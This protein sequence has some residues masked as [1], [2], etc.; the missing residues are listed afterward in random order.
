MAV[1]SSFFK[2]IAFSLLLAGTFQIAGCGWFSEPTA[3]EHFKK[4]QQYLHTNKM[5]AALI[6][7]NGAIQK[8]PDNIDYRT[9]LADL[10]IAVDEPS[11]AEQEL[12]KVLAMP[13]GNQADTSLRLG[14][15]LLNANQPDK[16]LKEIQIPKNASGLYKSK[17]L[18]LRAAAHSLKKDSDAACAQFGES[19]SLDENNVRALLGLAQC[20]FD[21]GDLE[22]AGEL[23]AV[24]LK[25]EPGSVD[26]WYMRGKLSWYENKIDDAN[27]A[28]SQAIKLNPY[29]LAIHADR[30]LIKI[31]KND[32]VGAQ[33]DLDAIFGR[34]KKYP[35]A[36]VLQGVL[37]FQNKKYRE[38]KASVEAALADTP[39]DPVGL[40]CLGLINIQLGSYEQA[41]VQINRYMAIVPNSVEGKSLLILIESQIGKGEGNGLLAADLAKA[42]VQK[43]GVEQLITGALVSSGNFRLASDRME[44]QVAK[45]QGSQ[46]DLAMLKIRAKDFNGAKALLQSLY[47]KD[48]KNWLARVLEIEVLILEKK[49]NDVVSRSEQL[50]TPDGAPIG[51]YYKAV[52]LSAL[53]KPDQAK[54]ALTDLL[55]YN[56]KFYPAVDLLAK[57][58]S[59][60]TRWEDAVSTYGNYLKLSPQDWRASIAIYNVFLAK[61]D[62]LGA[63]KFLNGALAK[64]PNEP[65]LTALLVDLMMKKKDMAGV[66][67]LTQPFVDRAKEFPDLMESR[68]GALTMGG[69]LIE[70][71]KLYK[72]MT[73]LNSRSVETQLNAATVFVLSGENDAAKKLL[74]NAQSK[75]PDNSQ[76]LRG[77]AQLAWQEG[78][79]KQALLLANKIKAI[80]PKRA[81]GWLVEFEAERR[82]GRSESALAAVRHA[83]SLEPDNSYIHMMYGSYLLDLN[84]PGQA[85]DVL[86]AQ[87]SKKNP[88]DQGVYSL[89]A[90][91]YL[92]LGNYTEAISLLKKEI[93]L[94]VNA[95]ASYLQLANVYSERKDYASGISVIN[96]LLTHQPGFYEAKL[97]LAKLYRDAKQY[98]ESL[99]IAKTLSADPKLAPLGF[100]LEGD[101]R[102]A[103]KDWVG[104][105]RAYENANQ[106][107]PTLQ[108]VVGMYRVF[109]DMGKWQEGVVRLRAWV[110][111]N[112]RDVAGRLAL[113]AALRGHGDHVGAFS[114]VN[115]GVR[116]VPESAV[117]LN[118]AAMLA[119]DLKQPGALG[120]AERAYKL[121]PQIAEVKDTYGWL[122]FTSGRKKEAM[123]LLQSAAAT[124]V[125]NPEIQYH[126]ALAL[127]DSGD[128]KRALNVM[129]QML[130][131]SP[132]FKQRNE[133]ERLVASLR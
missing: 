15:A 54:V 56:P 74:L 36:M 108:N 72:G 93:A 3:E 59:K 129:T 30:A 37:H 35:R 130:Q 78:D 17:V 31:L 19:H 117:L 22:K 33:K 68:A 7:L 6:E 70:A 12:R 13:N 27:G 132:T 4:S 91:A 73:D 83:A 84:L 76:I 97:V 104:A 46:L 121:A 125:D 110:R 114:V 115:E 28:Y 82:S 100:A 123:P 38:A 122:L 109:E 20:A 118:E 120:Y 85:V 86:R 69:K 106:G 133:V 131:R 43:S 50:R 45:G 71:E 53:G 55:K 77:L 96:Q 87:I 67:R 63:E 66:I 79:V 65:H 9:A 90:K 107:K 99:R 119:A 58:F 48:E 127:L 24:A 64:Q 98:D 8:S 81:D 92:R 113:I 94:N 88:T 80:D 29:K 47:Q 128:K 101:I 40:F 32:Y 16:L 49:Y 61:G 103:Q 41:H 126:F 60:E 21:K 116:I 25:K 62:A 44:G 95:P 39:D 89:L 75:N 57:N 2:P 102:F 14:E 111:D 52:G 112:P 124:L 5:Q 11:L 51:L 26:A 34:N 1:P 18:A 105:L 10:L 42:G 23:I